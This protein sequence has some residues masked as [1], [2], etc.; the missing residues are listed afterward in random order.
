MKL[1]SE[2]G[3]KPTNQPF[4][5]KSIEINDI[6]NQEISVIAHKLSPSKFPKNPGDLRLDLQIKFEDKLR[7]VWT[8]SKI[9]M[10]QIDKVQ[11]GDFPFSTTIIKLVPK[12]F[13]F[14]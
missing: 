9:L 1:F 8:T 10:D 3:I 2:M 14:T 6:L 4:E 12:G 5:G 7:V 11:T 13:K